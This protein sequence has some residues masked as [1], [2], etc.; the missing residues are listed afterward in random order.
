MEL[1]L[2][3][4]CAVTSGKMRGV[5]VGGFGSRTEFVL[6]GDPIKEVEDVLS[7]AKQGDVLLSKGT[8]A[9]ASS[10]FRGV[11]YATHVSALDLVNKNVRLWSSFCL[12]Q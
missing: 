2:G 7:K 11:T 4:K 5:H 1:T 3:L 10:V 12:K 6:L 9:L 8:A